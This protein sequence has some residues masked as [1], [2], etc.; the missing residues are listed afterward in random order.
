LKTNNKLILQK[1]TEVCNYFYDLELLN[2][3]KMKKDSSDS[4]N[5][6]DDAEKLKE[7]WAYHLP[8]VL[9]V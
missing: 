5:I 7:M 6:E 8:C 2:N 4:F 9:L 3:E 1:I